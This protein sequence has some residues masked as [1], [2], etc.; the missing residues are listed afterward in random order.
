MIKIYNIIGETYM[1]I[2][3]N[4][5][6]QPVSFY[7]KN[8]SNMINT[9]AESESHFGNEILFVPEYRNLNM[10]KPIKKTS[11]RKIGNKRLNTYDTD[12]LPDEILEEQKEEDENN[13]FIKEQNHALNNLQ[14]LTN[15]F[16]KSVPLINYFFLKQKETKIKETV[17]KLND[18]TQ[19]V[20]DLM[21]T[22]APFG[23][24]EEF[25][26]NIAKNLTNAASILGEVNKNL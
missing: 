9:N 23:E 17:D 7:P 12:Y 13:F 8:T 11:K 18:I 10:S 21:N 15:N 26:S 5:I 2:S 3:G 25:Y 20:D 1:E 4:S 16:V 24:D 22:P 19:N 6:N 14:K